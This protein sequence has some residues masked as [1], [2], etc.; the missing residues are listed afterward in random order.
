MEPRPGREKP[1]SETTRRVCVACPRCGQ[2]YRVSESFLGR[3]LVCRH[4]RE[5]WRA[6][7]LPPEDFRSGKLMAAG[8][9]SDG[10][11]LPDDLPVAGSSGSSVAIDMGWAGQQLGRYRVLSVLGQGGMGVVWRAHDDALRRDVALKILNRGNRRRGSPGGLNAELFMQEARAIARLQHPSVVAIYEVAQDRNE[12]FLALELMEGGTLQE[13]VERYGRI[14]PRELWSMMVGPA[15]ALALAHRQEIIHR[16]VKPSNLMFDEHG[17]L[18]LMDFGLADVAREAASERM[19]GKPVGS[20]GWIAPETARGEGTTAKSDIYGMGL[21]MLY[22]LLGRQPLHAYSK[23]E[24]LDLHRNPPEPK[25]HEIKGL[26][27]KA[28][29]LLRTCLAVD[30]AK[31]YDSA[32]LL[33]EALQECAEEDP[34]G[35]FRE[36]TSHVGIALVAAV[37]GGLLVGAV[38]F[39]YFASLVEQES[40]LR[41]P[42]V[43]RPLLPAEQAMQ[44]T[45]PNPTGA[46]TAGAESAADRSVDLNRPWPLVLTGEPPRIVGSKKD[47]FY[48][49]ADRECGRAILASD[50]VA[51]ESTAAAEADHRRPC[52]TCHPQTSERKLDVVSGPDVD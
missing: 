27:P 41:Q 25:L 14:P 17:H 30:P 40:N 47:D 20:L 36:R 8:S 12:I 52:P 16:D 46:V 49:R 15:R 5:E 22:A 2:G 38:A 42:V 39:R 31:R 23:A 9:S 4:C 6:T 3:R 48:H 19:R 28:A 26:T 13:Y 24:Y 45:P 43:R 21:V 18:K 44:W 33:A 10:V 1:A 11:D 51:Y 32:A 35:R 34:A 7:E 29:T 37:I 50:L